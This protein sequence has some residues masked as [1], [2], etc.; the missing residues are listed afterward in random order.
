VVED[1]TAYRVDGEIGRLTFCCHQVVREGT[2][3]FDASREVFPALTGKQWYRTVGFKELAI[4]HG[5]LHGSYRQTTQLLNRLR[6]Q[7]KATPLRTLQDAVEA[8]GVAA[9]RALEQ[10]ARRLVRQ[11]G[12]DDQTLTPCPARTASEPVHLAPAVVEGALRQLAP[13][14][15]TLSAMQN[16]PVKYEDP[17]VA[18]NVSI[19]DVLAKKQKEHRERRGRAASEP[20]EAAAKNER[21]TAAQRQTMSEDDHKRVHTT[22]AHV[23]TRQGQ[24][25]FASASVLTTCLFVLAFLVSNKRL[26]ATW[27]FFVDGQ[28]SL[29]DLLLQVFAWQGTVQLILDW[30]HVVKKCKEKL[31]LGLNHR[32]ARNDAVKRVLRPL[33]YG[34]VDAA[35]TLLRELDPKHIKAAKAIDEL[36][37]YLQRNRSNIPC[38]AVR[39]HLGLRTSSNRVEKANDV[40]VAARQKHKGMSWSLSGSSALATLQTMVCNDNH[41]QWL[42]KRMVDFRLAA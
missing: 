22:V 13:D 15:T 41:G 3:V 38:Y 9:S 40:V 36:I 17:S 30:Y 23:Q 32:H 8:E 12:F 27:I 37:G 11:E 7:P 31:S 1:P 34:D 35:I 39:R 4:V 26:R 18:V 42:D 28:R 2:V 16:N 19:D 20:P 24:R 21:R 6:H 33:W 14:E 29:Q 25:V 5:A 10:E